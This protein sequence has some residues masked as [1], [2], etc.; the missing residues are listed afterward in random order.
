MLHWFYNKKTSFKLLT[1][2]ILVAVILAG[3]SVYT[4][5]NLKKMNTNVESLYM[6]SLEPMEHL[7]ESKND[8]NKLRITW[9]EIVLEE[10]GNPSSDTIEK[11]DKLRKGA[12][13]NFKI[14]TDSYL[15]YGEAA[16]REAQ[17]MYDK[18][19]SE[20][21]EYNRLY[22]QAITNV[23]KNGD[24]FGEL[25]SELTSYNERLIGN[26]DDIWAVD[27]GM[28]KQEYLDS[29]KMYTTTTW[30]LVA[31]SIG[32]LAI[33]IG[34]GLF[35]S[36]AIARPLA[37]VSGIVEKIAE[38]DLTETVTLQREDEVGHL[39]K[40]LN[41]MV[42]QLR[43]TVSSILTA[44]DNLSASS[45]QVSA[46]TEE[47]ASASSEQA[48]SAQTMNELLRELSIA[49]ET[50]AANTETAAKLSDETTRIAQEG[51]KTVISAV[52]G[53]GLVGE[54]MAKLEK[55]S[56][57]IGEIISVI[58]D[59]A[60][61]T[62]LL[63]LNAA[64][65]AARAGDQGRGF[66]V[67]ADEVRKLAERS[68]EATKQITDIIKDMQKNT[69]QSVEAVENGMEY[70]RKSGEAFE[71]IIRMVNETGTKVTEI[72]SASEE[73]AAQS[74]EVL[75][76]IESISAATEEAAASSE[77]T[78]ATAHALADLSQELNAS[79]SNFKL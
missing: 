9:H 35:L 70:T 25:D 75:S 14:Y 11:V 48:N 23:D 49:I 54:Q 58:D 24:N 3:V 51:E 29:D 65:E 7:N 55:D 50:V 56:N 16:E 28:S 34:L 66:A 41:K 63:A 45:T 12:L 64:I 2:F 53:S 46:S 73:E 79:V 10:K 78:A 76:F 62:N 44:A 47:I 6:G 27:M 5:L 39:A 30:L 68:G 26:I 21:D 57:R 38:G 69:V 37:E 17:E 71:E 20:L 43:E 18:F 31:I 40:S 42:I 74:A 67:V 4:I 77:E 33:C 22:D 1:A 59:I 13:D 72:A 61:Q 8:L 32:T 36:R 52:E 60:D 19:S 15:G